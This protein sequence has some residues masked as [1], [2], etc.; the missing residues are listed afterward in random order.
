MNNSGAETLQ[1][2]TPDENMRPTVI[3]RLLDSDFFQDRIMDSP[4]KP[5]RVVGTAVAVGHVFSTMIRHP[6][7][8]EEL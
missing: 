5:V 1:P 3:E 2:P 8:F 4:R 7:Y 6:E